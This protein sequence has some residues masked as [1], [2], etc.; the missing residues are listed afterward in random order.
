M[1]DTTEFVLPAREDVTVEV[2]PTHNFIDDDNQLIDMSHLSTLSMTY[3]LHDLGM[4][5]NYT[6]VFDPSTDTDFASTR[7]IIENLML[8]AIH[9]QIRHRFCEVHGHTEPQPIQSTR[10][11]TP[12]RQFC[13]R[14]NE[15]LVNP[16]EVA[17][18]ALD[19]G[20]GHGHDAD[21]QEA[22]LS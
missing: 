9:N 1:T 15:L 17:A 10:P 18:A 14:C 16:D 20:H 2:T 5:F 6:T 22:P 19:V 8:L 7:V 13:T 21:V 11:V 4:S 3:V 12:I